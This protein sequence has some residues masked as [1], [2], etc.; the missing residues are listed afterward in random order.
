MENISVHVISVDSEF[1]DEIITLSKE[2]TTVNFSYHTSDFSNIWVSFKEKYSDII[3]IDDYL[4]EE[5]MVLGLVEKIINDYSKTKLAIYTDSNNIDLYNQLHLLGV[6]G[7]LHKKETSFP[8]AREKL[9]S[10]FRII[11]FGGIYYDNLVN[12]KLT[13]PIWARRENIPSERILCGNDLFFS[14]K[15]NFI[16]VLTPREIEILFK[17]SCHLK[18]SEI[19]AQLNISPHT[20]EQ[21]KVHIICKMGF[22]ST[23]ELAAFAVLNKSAIKR[24]DEVAN[25]K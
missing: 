1:I 18:N 10:F 12:S 11:M 7:I 8:E 17:I 3:F 21:H 9:F 19:A 24:F 22:K 13:K 5:S 15:Q 20:I 4:F 23:R 16:N 2:E 6:N 25:K 14:D